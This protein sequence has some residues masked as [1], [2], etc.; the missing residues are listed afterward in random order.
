MAVERVSICQGELAMG[1][2][3]GWHSAPLYG[4]P[5]HA[6]F[7]TFFEPTVLTLIAV[8]LVYRAVPVGT[9]CVTQIPPYTS[10]EEAL[11]AF[12]GELAVVF[13][14]RLVPT[15]HTLNMLLLLLL[16]FPLVLAGLAG[17]VGLS[18]GSRG[19]SLPWSLWGVWCPCWP[20]PWRWL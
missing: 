9:T 7:E 17:G 19:H 20:L 8:V 13:A 16:L 15:H 10:L 5:S 3:C 12:T 14:T 4:F 11:A 6:N 1:R 2:L 18:R